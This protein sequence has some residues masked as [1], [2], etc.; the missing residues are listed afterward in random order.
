LIKK[1]KQQGMQKLGP[2]SIGMTSQRILIP[3]WKIING[4]RRIWIPNDVGFVQ[5]Q[6]ANQLIDISRR[7]P[8]SGCLIFCGGLV[9]PTWAMIY[10]MIHLLIC[11][12]TIRIN[13]ELFQYEQSGLL[14]QDK[15]LLVDQYNAWSHEKRVMNPMPRQ[16]FRF[17]HAML[18]DKEPGSNS[19][20]ELSY[21]RV[22]ENMAGMEHHRNYEAMYKTS[23]WI[24][25]R[26]GRA[27]L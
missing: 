23:T 15:Q 4:L 26:R 10:H 19:H 9:I 14:S 8:V 24:L 18:T 13:P 6:I 5:L 27:A 7:D 3:K 17:P 25:P 21:L 12:P 1:K 16:D 20:N 11:D 22:R 2:Q